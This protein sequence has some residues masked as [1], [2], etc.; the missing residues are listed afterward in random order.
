[1]HFSQRCQILP[2]QTQPCSHRV[3]F[4]Q[5]GQKEALPSAL[6][7]DLRLSS[8]SPLSLKNVHRAGGGAEVSREAAARWK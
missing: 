8:E 2:E 6:D 7:L 1:M 4:S 5:H 3:I